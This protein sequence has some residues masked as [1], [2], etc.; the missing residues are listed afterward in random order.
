MSDFYRLKPLSPIFQGILTFSL[1]YFVGITSQGLGILRFF[2]WSLQSNETRYVLPYLGL[3]HIIYTFL[4]LARGIFLD[5]FRSFHDRIRIVLNSNLGFC[6]CLRSTRQR[7]LWVC[8]SYQYFVTTLTTICPQSFPGFLLCMIYI[9]LSFY[10]NIKSI[11]S[12][13]VITWDIVL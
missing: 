12:V 3:L 5:T 6:F 11:G 2:Q 13:P 4:H 9:G 8:P 1:Q 7:F 10:S